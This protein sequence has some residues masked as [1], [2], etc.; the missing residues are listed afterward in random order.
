MPVHIDTVIKLIAEYFYVHGIHICTDIVQS[1]I[2]YKYLI[3]NGRDA[4]I[5]NGWA[6]D[7][8]RRIYYKYC[9]VKYID[10]IYDVQLKSYLMDPLFKQHEPHLQTRRL[11]RERPITLLQCVDSQQVHDT[12]T[13]MYN[14]CIRGQLIESINIGYPPRVVKKIIKIY[15]QIMAL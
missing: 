6:V 12:Q 1:W 10:N 4:S 7:Y 5:I 2:I 3:K 8:T 14:M 9:W 13:E 11:T 15:N